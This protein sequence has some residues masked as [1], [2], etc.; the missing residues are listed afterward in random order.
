MYV[1]SEMFLVVSHVELELSMVCSVCLS[2]IVISAPALLDGTHG[3][4]NHHLDTTNG[5]G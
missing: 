4:S 5:Q 3:I 2:A 1:M